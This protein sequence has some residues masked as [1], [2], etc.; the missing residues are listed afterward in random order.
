MKRTARV[1]G[2]LAG[3]ALLAG[4]APAK[5]VN[6]EYILDASGSMKELVGGE[7]KMDIAKRTL[8]AL[9]DRLPAPG[10]E[11]ALNVGLR[12]YGHGAAGTADPADS[13]AGRCRDTALEVPLQGVDARAIKEKVAALEPQGWTPIAYALGQAK[14][15]FPPGDADNIVIL[16]SD[17]KE[18]CGGDPCAVAKELRASGIKLTIHVVGFDVKPEEKAAL[19]CIAQEA[20]GKYFGAASAQELNDVLIKA[21]EQ[22]LKTETQ[23]VRIKIGG[24]A[25]LRFDPASWVAG[26]PY[27]YRLESAADGKIA[28]QGGGTLDEVKVAPGTYRLVWHQSEH[29][30]GETVLFDKIEIKPGET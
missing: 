24:I 9:V 22:V 13:R 23:S 3:A 11:I 19:E 1:L 20:G 14:N 6:I 12:V 17:G 26:P 7:V 29:R 16:I 28:A 10:G 4:R 2:M 21:Q 18:T 25:K 8:S 27:R 5:T 30:I 15:D